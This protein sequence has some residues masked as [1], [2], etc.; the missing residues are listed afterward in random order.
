MGFLQRKR[1]KRKNGSTKG[2]ATN[3]TK[4]GLFKPR[5]TT[6]VTYTET[7]APSTSNVSH[8]TTIS[9]TGLSII[10]NDTMSTQELLD[11]KRKVYPTSAIKHTSSFDR[12]V[13]ETE[14]NIR[15]QIRMATSQDSEDNVK[16]Q[17]S[18]G[19]LAFDGLEGVDDDDAS[20]AEV[21]RQEREERM[22]HAEAEPAFVVAPKQYDPI[23]SGFYAP[24]QKGV[25]SDSKSWYEDDG[26]NLASRTV[27]SSRSFAS[28]SATSSRCK[29]SMSNDP[30]MEPSIE[31][32]INR[33]SYL[34]K[35]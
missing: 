5:K 24:K 22:L 19:V 29:D 35:L 11:G 9:T 4:A 13:V 6:N 34:Q 10:H 27:S 31:V 18:G 20:L 23:A 12:R 1:N 7:I 14:E 2:D 25:D 17:T 8:Y 28:Q 32:V 16:L 33:K 26:S 30:V 3:Q 21:L 15:R